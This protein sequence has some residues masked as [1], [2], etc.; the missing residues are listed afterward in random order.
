MNSA[1]VVASAQHN[2]TCKAWIIFY[3]GCG[4]IR[5][6]EDGLTTHSQRCIFDQDTYTRLVNDRDIDEGDEKEHID[7]LKTITIYATAHGIMPRLPTD[8][9]QPSSQPTKA[10]SSTRRKKSI[11]SPRQAP[12]LARQDHEPNTTTTRDPEPKGN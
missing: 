7:C 6:G 12:Q 8:P 10:N 11:S 4:C 1:F 3:R 5:E 9:D 2:P